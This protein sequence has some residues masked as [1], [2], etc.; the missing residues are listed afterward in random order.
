MPGF[1]P[2]SL[3]HML[4]FYVGS[5]LA[6]L[7]QK[8]GYTWDKRSF[9]TIWEVGNH[10]PNTIMCVPLASMVTEAAY[11]YWLNDDAEASW[12]YTHDMRVVEVGTWFGTFL[13]TDLLLSLVHRM[14]DKMMLVHHIIF[15]GMCLTHFWPPVGPGYSGSVMMAQEMSTPFLNLFLLSRG[16]FGDRATPT[17]IAFVIFGLLFFIFRVVLNTIV[18]VF[19]FME[20]YKEITTG[21]SGFAKSGPWLFVISFLVLGGCALQLFFFK[22]IAGKVYGLICGKKRGD[23]RKDKKDSKP[24][25][26]KNKNSDKTK[27]KKQ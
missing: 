12:G 16:F 13:I 9:V 24:G 5:L 1:I 21:V 18:T 2:Y 7:Y 14:M 15:L 17:V 22:V 10:L 4:S 11:N 20:L 26:K 27:S 8:A 25:K 19:Y 23:K 3:M 6:A